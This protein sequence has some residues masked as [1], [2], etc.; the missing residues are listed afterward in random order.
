MFEI[1]LIAISL[2]L[3]AFSIA[4]SYGLTSRG[5]KVFNGFLIA[6]SFGLFQAIMPLIGYMGGS[7]LKQFI[8]NI[9]HWVAFFLLGYIGL[10]MIVNA[11]GKK[12]QTIDL[13]NPKILLALSV[14]TSIDALIIGIGFSF[15]AINIIEACL[16]IGI[17]TFTLSLIGVVSGKFFKSLFTQSRL[18][19]VEIGGGLILILIGLRILLLHLFA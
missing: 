11:L 13:T 2:S 12:N 1:L 7:I 4:V 18:K 9:D 3:D 5:L 14:A 16:V 10:K 17:I 15:I 6:F 19:Y 8:S